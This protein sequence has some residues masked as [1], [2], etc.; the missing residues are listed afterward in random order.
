MD[1]IVKLYRGRVID[2]NLEK[3]PLP[4]GRE[5]DLEII[6]HPGGACALPLHDN[7][8]VTLVRQFRHAVGGL[9]W[10]VPAGRIDD[11]EDPQLAAERELKEETGIAA[12]RLEKLGE[13]IPTPGFCSEIVHLYLAR[14][15]KDCEQA[16]EDDEYL[17]VV[18]L[19]FDEAM[20]MVESGEITDGKTSVSLFLAAGRIKC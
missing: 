7:G 9:V 4:D 12:G 1:K 13:F 16:L 5:V 14:D 2:L 10:E 11:G 20:K 18:R 6:R 17:E 19:P 8:D 15:L 3:V